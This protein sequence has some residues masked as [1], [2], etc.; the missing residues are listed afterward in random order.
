MRSLRN[1]ALALG[2]TVIGLF[3]NTAMAGFGGDALNVTLT[4]HTVGATQHVVWNSVPTVG[5][6][7]IELTGTSQPFGGNP[8][9]WAVDFRTDSNCFVLSVDNLFPA[10]NTV[11]PVFF[12]VTGLAAGH[13][14]LA[15]F[16]AT[17][18]GINTLGVAPGDLSWT[19]DS[20]TISSAV[21]NA[22]PGFGTL[23]VEICIVPEA[24]TLIMMGIAATGLAG[25]VVARRRRNG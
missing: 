8:L 24:S 11:D 7:G 15:T 16:G 23:K 6:L 21:L 19:A 17:I 4:A 2:V 10:G 25:A 1:W 9:A 12:T 13:P 5:V 14:D 18:G 20:I 3:S 22:V